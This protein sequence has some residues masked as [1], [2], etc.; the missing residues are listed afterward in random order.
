MS[1]TNRLLTVNQFAAPL[2]AF[3]ALTGLCYFAA[4]ILVPIAT[5]VT[6]AYVLWPGV[7]ALRR[8]K[9]P[10][11]L[12]V[13]ITML[14]AIIALAAFGKLIMGEVCKFSTNLPVY[15]EQLQQLRAEHAKDLPKFLGF[16]GEDPNSI[17]RRLDLS[18]LSAISKFF[19][20]GVG[21]I[22]GFTGQ[23]I[24]ALLLTLFML[25][26][27]PGLHK[28]MV[29]SLG[30]DSIYATTSIIAEVSEQ[31]AGYLWVRFVITIGLAVVFTI[32]LMIGGVNYPYI[33]GPLA[34]VLNLV[35]YV[36]AYAGA[37]PPMIMP[38]SSMAQFYHRFG[39]SCSLWLCNSLSPI[40]SHPSC[41]ASTS[42]STCWRN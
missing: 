19:F 22:L 27:Q 20:K 23:V 10:H 42:T 35:P 32:G 21:S 36:G 38:I 3:A 2:L 9:V 31:V 25:I 34:A 28:R 15:W 24:L 26:E 40:L 6:L 33:W 41:S 4:P 17:L 1:D 18:K 11:L 37:I 5:G 12:A 29:R 14:V 30:H 8:L 39:C 16:L 13:I 7:A